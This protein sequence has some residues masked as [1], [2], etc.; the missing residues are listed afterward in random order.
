MF[1][2][3][4]QVTA[5]EIKE[6]G[7]MLDLIKVSQTETDD[8]LA[9]TFTLWLKHMTKFSRSAEQFMALV[10]QSVLW[11]VLFGAGMRNFISQ[12]HGSD[13]LSFMLPGIIALSALSGAVGGGLILLDERLRGIMKEYLVSPIPRLSILLGNAA[14]TITKSLLQAA[15][16]LGVGVLMGAHLSSN[17]FGWLGALILIS[18]FTLGFSGIALAVAAQAQS[19]AGY[20]GLIFLLNLPLLFASNALY[21]LDVLPGWMKV[22]VLINPTTYVI[23]SVRAWGFGVQPA[24]SLWASVPLILL[25]ACFGVWLALVSFQRSILN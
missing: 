25:F 2:C 13:Y 16:M 15:I 20:H 23:D 18:L 1:F 19:T 14:S 3:I 4:I 6:N 7:A 9:A 17:P 24:I 22:V 10:L 12:V 8:L 11:V 21:P 5:Y